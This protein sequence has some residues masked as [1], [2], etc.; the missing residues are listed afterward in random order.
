MTDV[1]YYDGDKVKFRG[2]RDWQPLSNRLT[3]SFMSSLAYAAPVQLNYMQKAHMRSQLKS[4][5]DNSRDSIQIALLMIFFIFILLTVGVSA[6]GGLLFF[7]I[8]ILSVLIVYISSK[9]RRKSLITAFSNDC[10]SAFR[11]TVTRKLHSA[12]DTSNT[13]FL[14]LNGA[15]VEV[16][17]K[18]YLSASV[19]DTAVIVVIFTDDGCYAELLDTDF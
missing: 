4:N 15:N 19:G 17:E 9:G 13:F 2:L 16:N 1:K 10:Y 14:R 7:L 12:N 8:S 5:S 18:Q 11:Y 3:D 6:T